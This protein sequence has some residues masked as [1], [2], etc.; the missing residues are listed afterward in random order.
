MTRQNPIVRLASGILLLPSLSWAI[1]QAPLVP[2]TV[3]PDPVIT[4]AEQHA[5]LAFR[6][7]E[8]LLFVIRWGMVKGGYSTLRVENMEKISGRPAYHV[9][10]EAHSTGL[11]NSFYHVNDRNETWLDTQPRSTFRYA[12]K[13]EEGSY[14]VDEQVELNQDEHRFHQYSY[15]RDKK[16][17]EQKEGDIPA[18]VLDVLGSLYYVRTLPLVVGH[19][20]T[21]DVHSGDK[22]YPLVVSVKKREKIRVRA[23]KFD[24]F[25]VEPQLRQPGIFISKGKKL[26]VWLTADERR[27]PVLMRSEIFIG[28][29][30]AELV[31]HKV[32]PPEERVALTQLRDAEALSDPTLQ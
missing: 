31:K 18:N 14:R 22:V 16:T 26:Q 9:V 7:G 6:E 30:S 11:V 5:P 28:H 25:L 4:V 2:N 1:S 20:Y 3:T 27:M 29:V 19:S 24:C 13:I 10:A 32:M 17:H 12:R 8:D 23:G 15:R 21:L